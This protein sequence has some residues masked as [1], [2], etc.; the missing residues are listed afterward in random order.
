MAA[1]DDVAQPL[2]T[3]EW[4]SLTPAEKVVIQRV[5]DGLS[6]KEVARRL[7]LSRLTVETHLKRVFAKLGVSSRTE[8]TARVIRRELGGR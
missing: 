2:T 8:L 7:Y 6:N 3:T 5:A 1:T 4:N